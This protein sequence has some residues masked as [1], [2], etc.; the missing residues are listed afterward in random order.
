MIQT[1][2]V[3]KARALCGGDSMQ[4]K[5]TLLAVKDIEKAKA[6][7]STV[8]GLSVLRD[9][10]GNMELSGG[11]VLQDEAI[12]RKFLGR[13]VTPKSNACELYFEEEDVDA[14]MRS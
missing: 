8:F 4:L 11:L 14:F 1:L 2:W 5:S 7:Y 3:R 6:F 12:W 9:N 10:D 13:D